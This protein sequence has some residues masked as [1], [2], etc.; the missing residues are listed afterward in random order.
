MKVISR[1][2][3]NFAD[4]KWLNSQYREDLIQ[5]RLFEA[6]LVGLMN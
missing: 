2:E 6:K 5:R 1:L 4:W 3:N